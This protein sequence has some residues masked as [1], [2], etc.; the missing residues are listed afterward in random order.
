MDELKKIETVDE[1]GNKTELQ[2][3]DIIEFEGRE[4]AL[5]LDENSKLEDEDPEVVLVYLNHK[6]NG[7][8]WFETIDD[9]KEFERISKSILDEIDKIEE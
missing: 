1:N 9:N 3:L 6:E 2:I 7:E 5:L 4:Y 8:F